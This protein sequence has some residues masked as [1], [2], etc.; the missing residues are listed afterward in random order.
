MAEGSCLATV[1]EGV[2]IRETEKRPWTVG[3]WT[4]GFEGVLASVTPTDE[5]FFT[6]AGLV[7]PRDLLLFMGVTLEASWSGVVLL[8]FGVSTLFVERD[9]PLA[10][11]GLLDLDEFFAGVAALG[12]F[13]SG[14][15]DLGEEDLDLG[16]LAGDA[17]LG[18]AFLEDASLGEE[19]LD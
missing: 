7:V 9:L 13:F 10:G 18:E 14:V 4:S 6:E 3:V 2:L 17:T 8:P 11:D 5:A 1:G 16:D 12:D 19:D 15:V